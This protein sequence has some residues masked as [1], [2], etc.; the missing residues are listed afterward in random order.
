MEATRSD[1]AESP[2]GK[3]WLAVAHSTQPVIYLGDG[4]SRVLTLAGRWGEVVFFFHIIF[5]YIL[6]HHLEKFSEYFY[7]LLNNFFCFT[8]LPSSRACSAQSSQRLSAALECHAVP[9]WRVAGRRVAVQLPPGHRSILALLCHC[10]RS[11]PADN[12]HATGTAKVPV[13]WCGP[14][15]MIKQ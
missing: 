12:A 13:F 4:L 2:L 7:S 15:C 10:P 5:L 8:P 1:G 3:V 11:Q 9:L 6:C 14:G